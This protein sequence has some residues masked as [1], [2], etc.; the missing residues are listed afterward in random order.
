[1]PELPD[2]AVFKQYADA[3][4]LH[5]EIA[6]VE[7]RA[8]RILTVPPGKLRARLI[9]RSFTATRRHGKH[10]FLALDDGGWLAL[11]FGMTGR[12]AYFKDENGAPPHTRLLIRFTNGY[13][14]AY[15][16]QRMLGE[17]G[18]IENPEAFIKEKGL[19]PDALD[20]ALDADAFHGAVA[21][22]R[23]AIK[24]ALM[25]QGR[26]AGIGNIYSDEIL[27]QAGL[28]P[29]TRASDLDKGRTA[30]LLRTMRNVL[31]KAIA[32]KADPERFPR[33]W[34]IPHRHDGGEC[35]RCGG[36]IRKLEAA[37]RHGY[38]CPRCQ[39]KA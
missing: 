7:P 19:G 30:R 5:Q 13:H 2:V 22:S 39:Q 9:G 26:L 3:T 31:R 35:P 4:A 8:W 34:L 27:F 16:S 23:A 17:V 14:L 37:G 10:L 32:K 25:D 12:Q 21:G 33:T 11:H 15:D 28:H 18:P 6:A 24:S 38:Y 20:P 29:R 1:M 36:R